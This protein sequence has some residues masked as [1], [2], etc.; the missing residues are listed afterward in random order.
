MPTTSS[1]PTILIFT[2]NEGHYSLAESIKQK[3]ESSFN[4][5]EI[6]EPIIMGKSYVLLYRWF[7]NFFR[8]PY[9]L[10]KEPLLQ[11]AGVKSYNLQ[12]TPLFEEH[13]KKHQPVACI[14]TYFMCTQT[15]AV[16]KKTYSFELF[17]IMANPRTIHPV[18]ITLEGV[19]CAF[20]QAAVN[21]AKELHSAADIRETGWFVR[22]EFEV[23]YD[24]KQVRTDLNLNPNSLTFTIVA[25]SEGNQ[26]ALSIFPH[27]MKH[28]I[29]LNIIV[30]CGSNSLLLNKVKKAAEKSSPHVKIVPLGFT[31]ELAPYLQ[32]ADLVV[33]KAGPNTI[34]EATATLTPFFA[35]SHIAGQE[36]GNLD[37]IKEYNLGYVEENISKASLILQNIVKNPAQLHQ[38]EES[39][40][41]TAEKNKHSKELLYSYLQHF[42]GT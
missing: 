7:P 3:L 28:N 21:E 2:A 29:P 34:F 22:S 19:N 35:I 39:L 12:K 17:N 36:D 15:L 11:Q 33:G 6:V 5:I 30:S 40:K 41:K 31:K 16:L 1:K 9:L 18:E 27:L 20:D 8:V 25:G 14:S 38:F 13:I 37:I 24:K 23:A 26:K 42:L 4:V 32:A 10:S